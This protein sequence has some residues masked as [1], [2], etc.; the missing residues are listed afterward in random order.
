MEKGTIEKLGLP[1]VF[2]AGMVEACNRFGVI[3]PLRLAHF[4][5]QLAHESAGFTHLVENLNYNAAALMRTFPKRFFS[6]STA[7]AYEHQPE[8][9]ANRVYSLRMGNG[10]EA[11][12][13]GWTYRGRGLIQLT[14]R[15]NYK[16]ASKAVFNDALWLV[17]N[18][19]EAAVPRPACLIA[20]W[21]WSA[22]GCNEAADHDDVSK[23]TK[24]INGGTN[25]LE[26]R[27]RLLGRAKAVLQ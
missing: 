7:Q 20:G 1:E 13:D 14:G 25:G 3:T 26:E 18:P 17:D 19:D 6:E 23:V 11:S 5:A 24:I 9:I 10:D 15:D 2:L 27:M 4:Y 16:A 8:R 12:G 21:Y 22:N